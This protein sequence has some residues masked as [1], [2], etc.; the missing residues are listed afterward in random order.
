MTTFSAE[1]TSQRLNR[2]SSAGLT[3]G[4]RATS[5]SQLAQYFRRTVYFE[6]KPPKEFDFLSADGRT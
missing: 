3:C 5:H 4:H 1:E 2:P 6:E